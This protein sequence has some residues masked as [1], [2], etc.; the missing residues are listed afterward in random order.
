[1]ETHEDWK[2]YLLTFEKC[3]FMLD[4][5]MFSD[6]K[7]FFDFKKLLTPGILKENFIQIMWGRIGHH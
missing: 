7:V 6:R 3:L 4:C 2:M 1:M 5:I